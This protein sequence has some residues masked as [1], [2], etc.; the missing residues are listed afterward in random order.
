VVVKDAYVYVNIAGD[1]VLAG[2]IQ[3]V[4]EPRAE[5][6]FFAY[7]RSYLSNPDAFS[8]DPRHLPLSE[9][10]SVFP[11]L[12][13][14]FQ[15]AGPDDYGRYLFEVLHGHRPDSPLDYL[16]D[17]GTASIGAL[18]FGASKEGPGR[19]R[20][21]PD[22]DLDELADAVQRLEEK[23][24]VSAPMRRLLMPGASLPGARPKALV[25]DE[26]GQQWIAK[27]SRPNDLFNI[28]IGEYASMQAASQL[29]NTAPVRFER[30]GRHDIFL[31]RR[32][33]R[34]DSQRLHFLS[35][36]T[37]LGANQATEE[38]LYR[39]FGYPALAQLCKGVSDRPRED[40]R[41]LFHR[42]A[43]NVMFGNR[44]DHLKNHGFLKCPGKNQ[45]RLS[46][47]YD[48]VPGAG[49]STH[50]IGLNA[51]TATPSLEVLLDTA[52]HF[53]LE[54]ADVREILEQTNALVDSMLTIAQDTGMSATECKLME[55]G[56]FRYTPTQIYYRQTGSLDHLDL[57][58]L[59]GLGASPEHTPTTLKRGH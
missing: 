35:A 8:L 29:I 15:D 25:V 54:E 1:D 33:D 57:S 41:E 32:F 30:L 56:T 28:P 14:A 42:L 39:D 37:L 58:N 49:G 2:R 46:P 19:S 27:F 3:H 21:V 10:V 51:S 24:P 11:Q 48:I 26:Q 47:A 38:T 6:Y 20:L 16:V 52:S 12:P 55:Q 22:T 34:E 45:Y 13:L 18:S 53:G 9:G 4:R 43:V 40:V 23:K 31:T 50:A 7:G 36:Y 17:N 44:D 5:R 59:D